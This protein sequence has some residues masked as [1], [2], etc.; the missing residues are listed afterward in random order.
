MEPAQIIRT[1]MAQVAQLRT[2]AIDHPPLGAAVTSIKHFQSRRFAYTYADLA[3]SD[4]YQAATRF[5]LDDLYSE[6]SY[7]ERDAQFSGIA[8]ALQSLLPKP[9]LA[10]AVALAQLHALSEQLDHAMGHAWLVGSASVDSDETGRYIHA[11]RTVDRR[12]DRETQLRIVLEIGTDLDRLTRFAGLRLILKMMRGPA[13]A[14]GLGALQHF[15]ELGF[16][17]FAAMGQQKPGARGFLEIVRARESRLI[18]LLFDAH[19]TTC[20][21]E[22]FQQ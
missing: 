19:F 1:A 8:G 15:L 18:D 10:T 21:A 20:H 3:A 17:T 4:Q 2:D 14:A 6:A 13:H 22:L 5:F 7:A 9:A 11:W 12:S 16:D